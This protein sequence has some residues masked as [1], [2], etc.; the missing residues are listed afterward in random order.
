MTLQEDIFKGLGFDESVAR[1]GY[2]KNKEDHSVV[3]LDDKIKSLRSKLESRETTA[4]QYCTINNL[5]LVSH[6]I[7]QMQQFLLFTRLLSCG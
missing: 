3:L 5:F 6:S 7:F 4:R 1:I 2:E